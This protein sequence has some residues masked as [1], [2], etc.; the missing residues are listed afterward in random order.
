VSLH[1]DVY[2]GPVMAKP[3]HPARP[4]LVR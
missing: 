3:H 1:R 4:E 2:R